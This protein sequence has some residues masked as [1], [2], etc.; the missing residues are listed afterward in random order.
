MKMKKIQIVRLTIQLAYIALV[1]GGLFTVLRPLSLVLL[2]ASLVFGNFFCGWICPFGT[3]QDFVSRISS[4]FIKNKFKMPYSIGK[5]LQF[6]RY[7][8]AVILMLTLGRAA[9]ALPFNSYIVSLKF[10][11]GREVEFLAAGFFVL[12]LVISILFERPFCNYLCGEGVRF[13]IASFTRIFSIKRK[14]ET[15][16]QCKKC[17]SVCPM[18][19]SVSTVNHVR[20]AQ[21]I[22][23]F[24]CISSCPKKGAIRFEFINVFRII[25]EKLT[26]KK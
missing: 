7:V 21:C 16:V 1:I 12:F 23:C 5:Y 13:G 6:I 14:N 4:L 8:L 9:G 2:I 18:N 19:I 22:N 11:G 10:L 17:D 3:M 15:C 20:N 26:K 25:K 24:N